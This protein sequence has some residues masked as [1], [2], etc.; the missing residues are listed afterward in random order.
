MAK[1]EKKKDDEAPPP[2]KPPVKPERC[3]KCWARPCVCTK[4][5]ADK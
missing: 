4:R 3:H 2:A 1:D 5:K